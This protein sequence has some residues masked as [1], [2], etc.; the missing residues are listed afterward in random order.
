MS[1][2]WSTGKVGMIGKSYDG[3]LANGGRR[4]RRRGAGDDRPDLGHLRWYDYKRYQ[5]RHLRTTDY[6]GY[7]SLVPSD[8]RPDA[9][10]ARDALARLR[11]GQRDET[12]DYNAFWAQRDYRPLGAA[13]VK[14]SVFVAHG[15]NDL[16][17]KTDQFAAWWQALADRTCPRKLWLC[18]AGHVDPFDFDA[19]SG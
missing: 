1:A 19:P 18:Q 3:T 5:R 15:V 8:G 17:V 6:L 2:N 16:N 9:S 12:G 11:R 7:L 13:K 4:H 14:A 10:A